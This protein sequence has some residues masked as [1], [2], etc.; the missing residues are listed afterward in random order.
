ELKIHD[1]SSTLYPAD[2]YALVLEEVDGGRKLP[3]IIG[4][5]EAQAI[6]V[7][8]V[9]YLPPRP[10]THDLFLTVTRQF[11]I[12]LKKILI[13]KAK[14]GV[15]YSYLYYDKDGEEYKIDSRTSDAI[16]LALRY[17]CPM[18]T[19]EDIMET[20]HLHDLGEGKFSVPITSVSV[21][22]LED[23]LQ[24]AID[25]EDYETA[26]QIRDEIRKRKE[27]L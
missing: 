17:K 6:K 27:N 19:T 26:S 11:G 15:F 20:E 10:L 23:A 25:K 12:E 21:E 24:K 1:M 7:M 9:K 3:I 16:A 13:Y 18:Y 5:M 22:L 2:A 14:D 4:H 8:M